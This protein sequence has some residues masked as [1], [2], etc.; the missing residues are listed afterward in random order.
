MAATT[1]VTTFSFEPGRGVAGP[2]GEFLKGRIA[3]S[4]AA[5]PE[6]KS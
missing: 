5:R 2:D 1:A 4:R 6:E 3:L